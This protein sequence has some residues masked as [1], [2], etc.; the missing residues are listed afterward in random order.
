MTKVF[1]AWGIKSLVLIFGLLLLFTR[2]VYAQDEPLASKRIYL[3]SLPIEVSK[4]V[5]GTNVDSYVV[6]LKKG[7]KLHVWVENKT[8]HSKVYFDTVLAGTETRFGSDL[9]ENSWSGVV[10]QSGDYEIRLA[11]YPVANYKLSA[12]L[13]RA[14]EDEPKTASN[15]VRDSPIRPYSQARRR[16]RTMGSLSGRKPTPTRFDLIRIS[17]RSMDQLWLLDAPGCNTPTEPR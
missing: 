3:V 9:S 8:D 15:H 7:Q 5:G 10:P 11:A 12:Y 4:T 14:R 6:H 13:T 16:T 1:C 2:T 17:G